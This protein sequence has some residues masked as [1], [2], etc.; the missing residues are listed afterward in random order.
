MD[1]VTIDVFF[2]PT[3][4]GAMRRPPRPTEHSILDMN[5]IWRIA[6]VSILFVIGAFGIFYWGLERGVSVEAA[7][8]LVVN[9]LVVMEISYLFSVRYV[10]GSSFT[11]QGVLGT[12]AV[13]IGIA[14]VTAA[15]FAFTYMPFLQRV[16]QSESVSFVHGLAVVGVGAAMMVVVEIEKRLRLSIRPRT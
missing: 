5:L 12:P 4:P 7:R 16:F 10:H 15:Q 13:L 11:W 1:D 8:T 2:E 9:T 3:E 6:F 14:A